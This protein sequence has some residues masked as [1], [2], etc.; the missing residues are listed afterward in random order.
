MLLTLPLVDAVD[1]NLGQIVTVSV[2]FLITFAADFLEHKNLLAFQVFQNRC[3]HGG[4]LDIGLAYGYV[5]IIVFEHHG[6]K[7]NLAAFFVLQTADEN[8]LILGYL[9]LL[10]CDFYYCVH[11]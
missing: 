4:T 10:A 3:L 11:F 1:L 2:H 7:R 9:E 6:V 5:T 8:L